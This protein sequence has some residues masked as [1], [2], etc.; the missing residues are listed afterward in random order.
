MDRD[1]TPAFGLA[2]S[3]E[4][5]IEASLATSLERHLTAAL[6][7]Q[8][9]TGDSALQDRIN[10]SVDAAFQTRI[11]SATLDSRLEALIVSAFEK[12]LGR[13]V[14]TLESP[15]EAAVSAA[16]QRRLGNGLSARIFF[17]VPQLQGLRVATSQNVPTSPRFNDRTTSVSDQHETIEREE[18]GTLKQEAKSGTEADGT[19]IMKAADTS[20]EE[21]FHSRFSSFVGTSARPVKRESSVFEQV[22][23]PTGEKESLPTA[24]IPKIDTKKS[25]VAVPPGRAHK[26]TPKKPK[27][28]RGMGIQFPLNHPLPS[29]EEV[30]VSSD[31]ISGDDTSLFVEQ[32]DETETET[33]DSVRSTPAKRKADAMQ[34]RLPVSRDR[35]LSNRYGNLLCELR[36]G[37]RSAEFKQRTSCAKCLDEPDDAHVVSCLHVY[38]EECLAALAYDASATDKD[39]IAC[40][41]CL[42]VCTE[43]EPCSGLLAEFTKIQMPT[44]EG[45]NAKRVSKE[46]PPEPAKKSKKRTSTPAASE[47]SDTDAPKRKKA[48]KADD[49][50]CSTNGPPIKF[51]LEKE[52]KLT[53]AARKHGHPRIVDI[54]A[55]TEET[56]KQNF[57][58]ADIVA[59]ILWNYKPETLKAFLDTEICPKFSFVRKGSNGDK[60]NFVI[61]RE[62]KEPGLVVTVSDSHSVFHDRG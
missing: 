38:C 22:V 46:A 23:A 60:D 2:S 44:I 42:E 15:I 58:M 7:Q 35:T 19:E 30:S 25:D 40:L 59:T 3:L 14:A 6:S 61:E 21:A 36:N 16:I 62:R 24:N 57:T 10:A 20:T 1:Q 9:E 48:K 55:F 26:E 5:M 31:H 37:A 43:A 27:I 56:S 51:L 45:T 28:L 12:H 32:D 50:P 49:P 17:D 47:K 4:A 54:T 53:S 11:G 33:V 8:L 13:L 18:P 29:E 52:S 34:V 41:K 39:E